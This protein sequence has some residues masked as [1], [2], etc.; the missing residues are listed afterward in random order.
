MG[1]CFES[2]GS[3]CGSILRFS[4]EGEMLITSSDYGRMIAEITTTHSYPISVHHRKS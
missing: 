3:R 1:W 4:S 2:L